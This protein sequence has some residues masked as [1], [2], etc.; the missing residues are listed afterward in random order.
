MIGSTSKNSG[1]QPDLRVDEKILLKRAARI[2]IYCYLVV[3]VVATLAS[4]T[5]DL[6]LSLSDSCQQPE[7]WPALSAAVAHQCWC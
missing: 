7:I 5:R 1:Q 3:V 4:V 6:W 2:L